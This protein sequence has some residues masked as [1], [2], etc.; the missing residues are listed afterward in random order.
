MVMLAVGLSV[1]GMTPSFGMAEPVVEL[2]RGQTVYVPVYSHI[3]SG[4]KERPFNLAITLSFRNTDPHRAVTLM[5]ADY[6]DTNGKLVTRYLEKELTME[7]QASTRFVVR[8]S[9][10]TGGSG[11]HFLVRWRSE[12]PV[13]IPIVE[14]IMIGTQ[15]QQGISFTSRGQPIREAK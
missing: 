2:S 7:P 11:A 8:E 12:Q 13:N 9:D 4:D 3:Y 10:T 6:F 1:L 15:S 5:S 14:S